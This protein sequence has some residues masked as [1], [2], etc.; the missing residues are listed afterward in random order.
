MIL[1]GSFAFSAGCG[2]DDGSPTTP[3]ASMSSP[4]ASAGADAGGSDAAVGPVPELYEFASAF[5]DGESAIS[6]SGQVMRHVLIAEMVNYIDGLTAQVGTG[7][8]PLDGAILADLLFYFD[9]D[10]STSGEVPLSIETTPASA[11]SIYNDVST[12]KNL[13]DKTAGN[14]ASTDHKVWNTPGNF[15]GFAA[16][17]EAA[18]TPTKLIEYWF[19]QL[20]DLAFARGQSDVPLDPDGEPVEAVYLSADGH[21]LKQLIQKFLLGAITF[22]QASDD[23]L[24]DDVDGK[25]LLSP[26]TREE[27]KSYSTLGH[28]W[29]EAFGYFGAARDYPAYTDEEL[30]GGEGRADYTSYHDSDG[31]DK[32][33]LLREYNFGN[34][35]NCAKRD[36]GSAEA[37]DFTKEA[38]DAFWAGRKLIVETT[39]ELDA[40]ALETLKGHRDTAIGT[41]EKCIAATVIHYINDVLDDMDTFGTA[42][43]NFAD[44]AKHWSELKGFALGLQFNPSSPMQEGTRFA[45]FHSK[46]G[47]APVLPNDAGGQNAIDA[48]KTALQ[49]ARDMIRDAYE[50]SQANAE[51]W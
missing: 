44:H 23:Y 32:I 41:W 49:E 13:R 42:D 19:N 50:F 12:D 26:N 6:Y 45:D 33:D 43:Y 24:G 8:P 35:I 1:T 48:Y 3:D 2:D 40:A 28:A 39:G 22:A 29:D 46:I 20:D 51:A 14:D 27:G 47:D 31:N 5:A 7:D 17:G 37:T 4:D 21:D 15:I 38:F 25:G 18:D 34:S 9:F 30:A 11:Q 10:S 36:Q 16:G